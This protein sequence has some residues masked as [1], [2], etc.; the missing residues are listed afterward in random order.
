MTL[1]PALKA[2]ARESGLVGHLME[3]VVKAETR[4][5]K[6]VIVKRG[7]VSREGAEEHPVRMSEWKRV[8]VEAFRASDTSAT[9]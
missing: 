3:Y 2:C 7:F 5:G 1:E 6:T 9:D 8:W 4:D